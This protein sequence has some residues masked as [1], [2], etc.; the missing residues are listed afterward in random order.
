MAD[1]FTPRQGYKSRITYK[2]EDLKFYES[3]DIAGIERDAIPVTALQDGFA[4]F[5]S[6]IPGL[7]GNIQV[8]GQI[9]LDLTNDGVTGILN[10][11][12]AGTTG[13]LCVYGIT[14]STQLLTGA[15]FPLRAR[16]I[17]DMEGKQALDVMLQYSGQVTGALCSGAV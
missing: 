10:D 14:G 2:G 16:P 9:P 7:Y 12:N 8:S 13:S 11:F 17:L 15:A 1:T 4:P 5:R 6:V 3:P